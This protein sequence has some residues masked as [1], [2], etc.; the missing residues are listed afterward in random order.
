MV[1]AA[2]M[3]HQDFACSAAVSSTLLLSRPEISSSSN[4]CYV[5]LIVSADS[6]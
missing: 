5:A 4:A 2:A 3:K 6:N 1:L